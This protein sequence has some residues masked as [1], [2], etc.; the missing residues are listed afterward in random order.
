[1]NFPA[2]LYYTTVRIATLAFHS[3]NYSDAVSTAMYNS[4][5]SDKATGKGQ[6]SLVNG[7][8]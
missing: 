1:M 2:E 4:T 7:C 5:T 8:L 6:I 3:G